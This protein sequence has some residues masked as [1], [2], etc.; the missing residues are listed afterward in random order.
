MVMEPPNSN[1]TE[2]RAEPQMLHTL[3]QE[4]TAVNPYVQVLLSQL[5]E[6][7]KETEAG[8]LTA[9]VKANALH[10]SYQ[11]EHAEPHP[12][13][14]EILTDLLGGLQFQDV[15][16]QRLQQVCKALTQ[17]DEHCA[18]L[19]HA[20]ID[21]SWQGTLDAPL[22]EKLARFSEDYVMHSQVAA[23]LKVME[24]AHQ[25]HSHQAIELF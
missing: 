18:Q 24:F 16:R 17:L 20:A 12:D 8:V 15:V 10:A 22:Q 5:D 19:A 7:L 21:P 4:L 25:A 11:A 1:V 2:R 9:I 6:I 3:H 23:H 14:L 13:S